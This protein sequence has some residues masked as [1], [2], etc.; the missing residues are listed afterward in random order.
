MKRIF[1]YLG[2]AVLFVLTLSVPTYALVKADD[3]IIVRADEV[4][5]DDF[6]AGG[7]EVVIEGTINGDVYVGANRLTVNGTVN[8]DVIAGAQTTVITGTIRDDLRVGGN[9]INLIGAD[10]GDSVSV[11]GNELSIDRDSRVGGGLIFGGVSLFL[12]GSVG[13]GIMSG[14]DSVRVDGPVGNTVRVAA[15]NITI[16]QD[17]VIAGDLNYKSDNEAEIFGEIAGEVTR[18]EGF[19]VDFNTESF[20]RWFVVGYN[21]WAFIGAAII[22]L[23]A[24]LLVPQLFKKAHANFI[25][26]PWQTIGVGAVAV[27]ATIPAV[28]L[29]MVTVFGI[30]LAILTLVLWMLGIY[31]AKFFVAYSVG[32]L[33]LKEIRKKETGGISVMYL[34][35]IIGLVLYYLLRLMP[36]VGILVRFATVLIGFGMMLMLYKK[37]GKLVKAK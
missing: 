37:P 16:D 12:D 34:A 10:I 30:P 22:G 11:A 23:L 31:F 15:T 5:D 8:G 4:I 28:I 35:M 32:S 19:S 9:T 24:L 36:F 14:S 21:I 3:T 17:A 18:S 2:L 33:I 29:L 25:K 27:L 7:N 20:F 13:R 1:G 6:F 26:K